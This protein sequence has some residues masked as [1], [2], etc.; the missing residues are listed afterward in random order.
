LII[1]G[2]WALVFIWDMIK[3]K[4]YSVLIL[5]ISLL[6]VAFWFCNSNFYNHSKTNFAQSFFSLG[7]IYLTQNRPEMAQSYYDS[8]LSMNENL[9]RAR[10]NLGIIQLRK[11]NLDSAGA[12]FA[13]VLALN[14]YEEKAY[15]NLSTVYRLKGDPGKAAQ[16]AA[17]AVQLR[18]NYGTA[19]LNLSLAYQ[20]LNLPDSAISVLRA[21]I[22][23]LPEDFQLRYYLADLYLRLQKSELAEQEFTRVLSAREK[24]DIETYDI[25]GFGQPQAESRSR[26]KAQ[27]AYYLGLIKV[28]RRDW[29]QAERFFRLALELKPDLAE[30]YGNLGK[31]A[32]V[33]GDLDAAAAFHSRAIQLSPRNPLHYYNRAAT[34]L[35]LGQIELAGQDLESALQLDPEFDPARK[36][37]KEI[38]EK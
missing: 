21:G 32:E 7:N 29:E 8:A 13:T 20:T 4:N 6:V 27:A 33:K 25:S 10:L 22:R 18:P 14:P 35:N 3:T 16:F 5:P 30:A 17:A 26:L 37:L 11:G 24:V 28:S 38:G 19:Y 34:Y 31:L 2:G 23:I 1:L 15:N 9:P 36:L 12:E